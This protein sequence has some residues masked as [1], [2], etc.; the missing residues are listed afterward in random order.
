MT[1]RKR[2]VYGVATCCMLGG[3]QCLLTDSVLKDIRRLGGGKNI[4]ILNWIVSRETGVPGWMDIRSSACHE[5]PSICRGLIGHLHGR[6][7]R[8]RVICIC[9][10]RMGLESGI[11]IAGRTQQ[12]ALIQLIERFDRGSALLAHHLQQVALQSGMASQ[13]STA[14]IRGRG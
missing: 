7:P 2:S 13:P 11:A 10:A 4:A 3:C 1:R 12:T 8:Q 9:T 14:F 6:S 5:R